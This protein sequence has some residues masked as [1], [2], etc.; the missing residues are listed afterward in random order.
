MAVAWGTFEDSPTFGPVPVHAPEATAMLAQVCNTVDV[1]PAST[2]FC[3]VTNH[4]GTDN[5]TGHSLLMTH[6]E[7][8]PV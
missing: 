7:R 4:R 2:V 6:P 3:R 5:V 1:S 8:T